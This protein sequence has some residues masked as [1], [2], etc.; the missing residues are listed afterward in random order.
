MQARET[1]HTNWQCIEHEMC[2]AGERRLG[3]GEWWREQI[4]LAGLGDRARQEITNQTA[5]IIADTIGQP[6]KHPSA[7][8][9]TD[10]TNRIKPGALRRRGLPDSFP[11][12]GPAKSST[13]ISRYGRHA[14]SPIPHSNPDREKKPTRTLSTLSSTVSDTTKITKQRIAMILNHSSA[15]NFA[16]TETAKVAPSFAGCVV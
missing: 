7:A 3:S 15:T 14:I 16:T 1:T 11:H 4:S 8:T 13:K 2:G 12:P 5:E 6:R 9:A 10:R